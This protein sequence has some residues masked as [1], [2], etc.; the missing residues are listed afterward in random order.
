MIKSISLKVLLIIKMII[1]VHFTLIIIINLN[2]LLLTIL[3]N[4]FPFIFPLPP[5]SFFP[6]LKILATIIK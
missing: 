1:I 4:F 2:Q 5:A 3:L 6:L